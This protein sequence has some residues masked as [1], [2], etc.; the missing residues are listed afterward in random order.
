MCKNKILYG[1][2]RLIESLMNFHEKFASQMEGRC[3]SGSTADQDQDRVS[4]MNMHPG[5]T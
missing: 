4:G 3:H 2:S 5:V 1:N